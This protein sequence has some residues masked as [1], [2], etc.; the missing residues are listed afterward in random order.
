M[1]STETR[2]D[3][4]SLGHGT[5]FE[6]ITMPRELDLGPKAPRE[7]DSPISCTQPQEVNVGGGGSLRKSVH[8]SEEGG[9]MLYSARPHL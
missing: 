5:I 7:A 1:L 6:P 4:L 9:S 3:W 2:S 8:F